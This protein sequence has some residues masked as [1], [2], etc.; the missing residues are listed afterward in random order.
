MTVPVPSYTEKS[1]VADGVTT[2]FAFQQRVDE[3]ADIKVW[4]VEGEVATLQSQS[5]QYGLTGLGSPLV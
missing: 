1:W 5:T 4:L 2:S 3:A